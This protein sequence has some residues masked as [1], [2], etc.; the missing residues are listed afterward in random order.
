[1]GAGVHDGSPGGS[2]SNGEVAILGRIHHPWRARRGPSL[3]GLPRRLLQKACAKP[4]NSARQ[5]PRPPA[6]LHTHRS[7]SANTLRRFADLLNCPAPA[8]MTCS[9]HSLQVRA[10][11]SVLLFSIPA[12]NLHGRL[13]YAERWGYVLFRG[14]LIAKAFHR[15][16]SVYLSSA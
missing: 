6:S 12:I 10:C 11:C 3:W 8:L 2:P 9:F 1:M 14:L 15:M 4:S 5:E 13:S 16:R 7:D